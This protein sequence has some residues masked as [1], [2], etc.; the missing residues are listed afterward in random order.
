MGKIGRFHPFIPYIVLLHTHK[1]PYIV[2]YPF[3]TALKSLESKISY[4]FESGQRHQK[5]DLFYRNSGAGLIFYISESN[6]LFGAGCN[7]LSTLSESSCNASA[8]FLLRSSVLPPQNEH[9]SFPSLQKRLPLLQR[10]ILLRT[11]MPSVST[12]TRL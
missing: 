11:V 12:V 1:T 5:S 10:K 7:F 2:I 9:I 3:V 6:F 4:R 8:I